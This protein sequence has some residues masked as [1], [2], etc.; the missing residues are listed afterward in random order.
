M[1]ISIVPR[2]RIYDAHKL[3]TSVLSEFSSFVA[4]ADFTVDATVEQIKAKFIGITQL[5][6][7]HAAHEDERIHPLLKQKGSSIVEQIER[8]HQGHAVIFS[9]LEEILT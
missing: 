3:V 8:E 2:Y 1:G 5:I 4:K 9:S 6:H 7:G